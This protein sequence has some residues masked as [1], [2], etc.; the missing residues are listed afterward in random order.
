MYRKRSLVAIVCLYSLGL[1]IWVLGATAPA[2][3]QVKAHQATGVAS[4]VSVTLGKPTELGF[5]L[6]K[7]SAIPAGTIIFKVKN[8]GAGAH[9]F[10]ICTT[11]VASAAKNACVGKVT[12]MLMKGQSATLTVRLTKN[13]KYEYLCSITGHAAAGMKGLLGIGVKV[14]SAAS[15]GSG[16][17]LSGS[18]STDSSTSSS[19]TSSS[20]TPKTSS[21]GAGGAGGGAGD[22]GCPAGTTV[23]QAAAGNGGDHDDDDLGGADDAD[24]CI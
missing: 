23:A 17:T 20:S 19:S 16:N 9:N 11:P 15:Q 5:K 2:F 4:V 7:F 8:A 3:G 21:G 24:G 13:G 14:T 18:S 1:M 10:K 12:K 6:S 22:V